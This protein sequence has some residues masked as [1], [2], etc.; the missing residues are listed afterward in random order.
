M[1]FPLASFLW[2]LLYLS[3]DDSCLPHISPQAALVSPMLGFPCTA[4]RSLSVCISVTAKAPPLMAVPRFTFLH[5]HYPKARPGPA[6]ASDAEEKGM[7]CL[8]RHRVMFMRV[9]E[10]KG[11][12]RASGDLIPNEKTGRHEIRHSLFQSVPTLA[13]VICSD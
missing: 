11:T 7:K 13:V 4:V 5:L 1:G 10:L 8:E 6:P 2:E 3:T 9:L 12:R